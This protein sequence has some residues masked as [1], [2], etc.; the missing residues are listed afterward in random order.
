MKKKKGLTLN[1]LE[2]CKEFV[3]LQLGV[4]ECNKYKCMDINDSFLLF[5]K[6]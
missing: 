3:L 5:R 1:A 4:G 6:F 2:F